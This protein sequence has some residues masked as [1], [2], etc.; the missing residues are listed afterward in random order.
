MIPLPGWRNIPSAKILSILVFLAGL[1][2]VVSVISLFYLSQHLVSIKTNEIDKH[3]SML[4]VEGAVQTS[5]NRVL[6]LVLD[7]SIWDDAVKQTY[8]PHLDAHWLYDS[9]GSGFKINNLYDGTFIL[10]ENYRILWGAFRSEPFTESD[11]GFFGSGLQTLIE[12]HA[13]ALRRGKNAFAGITRTRAG[14]AFVGI[15]LI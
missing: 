15:G 13:D 6:S 2:L 1:G 14:I 4:S 11:I 12:Q 8:T 7:N 9:W 10:D 5:V 3:R